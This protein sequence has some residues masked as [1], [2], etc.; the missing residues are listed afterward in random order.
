VRLTKPDAKP[1]PDTISTGLKANG[2]N[3]G[4]APA[5]RSSTITLPPS[6]ASAGAVI[7]ERRS[8]AK[9]AGTWRPLPGHENE[10]PFK[11]P[12][13]RFDELPRPTPSPRPSPSFPAFLVPWRGFENDASGYRFIETRYFEGYP[14][15]DWLQKADGYPFGFL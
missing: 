4:Q 2:G 12:W 3:G 7:S 8:I 5:S 10:D 15:S 1:R 11:R 13:I 9:E 14:I 6:W